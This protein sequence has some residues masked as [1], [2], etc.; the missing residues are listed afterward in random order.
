MSKKILS[1]AL[2]VVMLFSICA[3]AVSAAQGDGSENIRIY[4]TSDAEIGAAAGT[5]VNVSYYVDLPDGV[6][7]LDMCVGNIA[8]GY[9]SAA[10]KVNSTG[11]TTANDARTW[12]ADFEQYMKSTANVTVSTT[13]SNNILKKA[14]TEETA[15][16]DKAL[17]VQMTYDGSNATSSTGIPVY[18]NMHIFTLSFVAQKTLTADDVIG[19]VTGAYNSSFFKV[20]WFNGTTTA[21]VYPVAQVNMADAAAAPAT[22]A[23]V[24]YTVSFVANGGTGSMDDEKV[25]SGKTYTLPVC[26]FV[27]PE[28]YEFD[29]WSV[30]GA[31]KAVGDVITV[32]AD[33][34]VTAE[35]K[36]LPPD[37]DVYKLSAP[38]KHSNGDNTNTVAVF[39]AFDSIDPDFNTAGT[40]QTISAISA[41]VSATANSQ[42]ITVESDPI[43]Y[44]Y[45]LGNGEYGFRVILKNVPDNADISVVPSVVTDGTE[46]N[47]ETVSFNVADATVA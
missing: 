15:K 39:F 5:V 1:L 45:D 14:T 6:D 44:V 28:G 20:C 35:W 46:Y 18:D 41:T 40:S 37:Y 12:G 31:K 19:V 43:K 38:R 3:V 36:E 2:A 17:Q 21:Q 4:L 34:V 24:E 10:Y 26:G 32:S 22:P 16:W 27:A 23:V 13:I 8:I 29:S 9:N 47:V 30:G 7:E 33:T 42:T 25:E 11:T